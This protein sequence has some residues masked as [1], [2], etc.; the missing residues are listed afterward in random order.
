MQT[1]TLVKAMTVE[2]WK[3]IL[4]NTKFYTLDYALKI[5]TYVSGKRKCINVNQIFFTI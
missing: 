3:T 5:E 2:F 1:S 4:V